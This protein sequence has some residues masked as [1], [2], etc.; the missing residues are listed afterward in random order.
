MK[1]ITIASL[2]GGVGKTSLSIFLSQSFSSKGEKVLF[3]DLDPNNNATDYFLADTN[4]EIIERKNVS[5]VLTKKASL[6]DCIHTGLFMD[7]LPATLSLV[8]TNQEL[9]SNPGLLLRFKNE[10][11]RTDYSIIVIDTPPSID[12]LFRT[13]LYSADIVLCPLAPGR[14]N[15]QS[16][17]YVSEEIQTIIEN[18]DRRPE[19]KGVYSMVSKG[20]AETKPAELQGVKVCKSAILRQASIRS[21]IEKRKGQKV[22]SV[23]AEMFDR[24]A[25]EIGGQK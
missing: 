24:L 9:A 4:T 23:S 6:K 5:H 12:P 3:I 25:D 15:V 22:A 11:Q 16:L 7:V 13:G 21:A 1:I 10:L 19:L 20:Q 17:N 18:T 2:K 8:K 14:W